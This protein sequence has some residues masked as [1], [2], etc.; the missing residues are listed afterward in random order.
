MERITGIYKIEN[1]INHK[2][3]IGQSTDIYKRWYNHKN[4]LRKGN[5]ANIYLQNAYNKYGEDNFKFSIICKCSKEELNEKE[6]FYI[7]SYNSADRKYG[8][9]FE[10]GGDNKFHGT[11]LKDYEIEIIERFKNDERFNNID[12][13]LERAKHKYTRKQNVTPG[14][15]VLINT[16]EIFEGAWQAII[17][18]PQCDRSGILKCCKPKYMNSRCGT[19]ADGTPMVWMFYD[20]YKDL[21]KEDIDF[22]ILRAKHFNIDNRS[23]NYII[24]LNNYKIFKSYYM[25]GDYCGVGFQAMWRACTHKTHTAG[26]DPVTG[27][28]LVWRILN[29]DFYNSL[30]PAEVHH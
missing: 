3:Y 12:E 14:K 6:I 22:W 23:V 21:S 28:R 15:I 25:A 10:S 9:N 4:K 13:L 16:G 18:Y 24:C 11:P 8:Y 7:S 17:K 1:L 2:V 26:I 27:E 20:E 30:Y 5:G 19:L 29:E